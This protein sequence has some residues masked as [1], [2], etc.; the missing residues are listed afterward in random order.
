MISFASCM[1]FQICPQVQKAIEYLKTIGA[2]DEN[3]QLTALG[4]K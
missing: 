3:E 4:K 2:L 1:V